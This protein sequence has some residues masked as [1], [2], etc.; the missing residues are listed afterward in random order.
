MYYRPEVDGLRAIAVLPV[1]LFHAGI[2]AFSGGYLG[3]DVFFVISGYLITSIIVQGLESKQGFSLLHFYER[4]ARR[5]LPALGLTILLTLLLAP[6]VL[7]PEQIK[8]VGQSVFAS[9]LFASNYFF[10]L[11][12][13]YFNPFAS[14]AP[15][16]HTW[17]LAVEEQFYVIFPV[18]LIILHRFR[19]GYTLPIV[20]IFTASLVAAIWTTQVN[21]QLSFYSIHTRAWELAVGAGLALHMRRLTDKG[22]ITGGAANVI[23]V[24]SLGILVASLMMI[25]KDVAHPGVV[26]LIPVLATALLIRYAQPDTAAYK[27]LSS[28]SLVH[29][30]L[31]SYGLYLYHNPLFSYVDVY[32]DYLGDE[33]SRIKIALIPLVYII[34]LASLHLVER[35][36]LR[37]KKLNRSAVLATATGGIA[38]VAAIGLGIHLMNGFQKPL[39]EYYQARGMTPLANAEKEKRKIEEVRKRFSPANASFDCNDGC[40]R[41]LVIGDSLAED[42]F[43]ALASSSQIGQFRFARMDDTCMSGMSSVREIELRE[44][45]MA[46]INEIGTLLREADVILI[47]AKWQEHTW[48]DG[49]DLADMLHNELGKPVVIFGSAMFTDLA[50]FS[51]KAWRNGYSRGEKLNRALY[52]YQRWDRL[53]TNDKLRD[54]TERTS[55]IGWISRHAFFCDRTRETCDLFNN[56]GLPLIWDNAHLTVTAYPMY[57]QY[58]ER[59]LMESGIIDVS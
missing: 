50:S 23:G 57:A 13:D 24:V 19:S 47:A 32:F 51:V 20:L 16:L 22:R 53:R 54:A 41:Y 17:S 6:F 10:Y 5:I 44:P 35:P 45:C 52:R 18:L 15:L 21:A 38:T 29:I 58:I 31:M 34:A 25:P 1:I 3:V 46:P 2:S 12:I 28:R 11:E 33:T 59:K 56:E 9:T 8:D 48:R 55:Q 43:F 14:K 49:L 39:T 7:M 27:V 36:A 26:T 42:T 37:G 40:R 30:G 4:R